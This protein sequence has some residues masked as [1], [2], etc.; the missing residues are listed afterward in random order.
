MEKREEV[1]WIFAGS[2]RCRVVLLRVF[3]WR[4]RCDSFF[5]GV[6]VGVLLGS[7]IRCVE[8]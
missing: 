1:G 3:L 7:S 4:D 8:Y 6:F 2:P 5:G